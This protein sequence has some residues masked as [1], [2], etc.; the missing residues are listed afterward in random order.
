ME[1]LSASDINDTIEDISVQEIM[2]L[3]IENRYEI[4]E[5]NDSWIMNKK[6]SNLAVD[7]PKPAALF[8]IGD[9]PS[10]VDNDVYKV[11]NFS[12]PTKLK[13]TK[14]KNINNWF[15]VSEIV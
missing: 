3:E 5:I 7:T 12:L 8:L 4:F 9:K 14:Y 2:I 10:K 11:F 1:K 13:L 15:K 6:F